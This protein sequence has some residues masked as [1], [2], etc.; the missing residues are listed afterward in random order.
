MVD[1]GSSKQTGFKPAPA[2][3]LTGNSGKKKIILITVAY[4]VVVFLIIGFPFYFK[5]L[6]SQ[7]KTI[8]QVGKVYYT[9]EDLIKRL[10]LQ[11]QASGTNQLEVATNVLQEMQ[12]EELIRQETLKQNIKVTEQELDQEVKRR[13]LASAPTEGNFEELYRAVLRR[14]RLTEKEYRDWIRIDILRGKLLLFYLEKTPDQAEQIHLSVLITDT[15]A[16]AEAVRIRLQKGDDFSRLTKETSLDLESAK[17]GGDLGWIPKGTD[18]LMTPGQIR[19]VGILVRTKAEAEKLRGLVMAGQ[20]M[21]KL[22]RSY[23]LDQETAKGGGHLGWISADFQEGKS[24]AAEAYDLNPGE[25]TP[26]V[27]S[28]EGFWIIRI[29][30]KTP[31][32]KVIDDIAFK[33][34]V[35]QISPPLNTVKGFYILKITGKEPQHCLSREQRMLW[36]E[37]AFSNWLISAA[38]KGRTE[39][40]IKWDWGSDTYNYV[41]T[42]LN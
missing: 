36:G 28:S 32:G 27:Q 8:L 41:V 26:P 30:E 3:S 21:E 42:H 18:D 15:A 34:S 4:I 14:M 5:N 16:H 29:L 13:I 11:P 38:E 7:R 20:D 25:I 12:N 6:A 2:P 24:Y 40:R 35:G 33:L 1:N 9:T 10:R 37:K 19:A 31:R 23:S 22:A 17:K 39:G